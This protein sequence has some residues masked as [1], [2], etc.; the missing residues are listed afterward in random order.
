MK[1]LNSFINSRS[2][3]EI[4]LFKVLW[5]CGC[6]FVCFE[7]FVHPSFLKF[8]AYRDFKNLQSPYNNEE[9]E[10]FLTHFNVTSLPFIKIQ[11]IIKEKAK[12]IIETKQEDQKSYCTLSFQ[13]VIQ[14]DKFFSLLQALSSPTLLIQSFSL[15]S[16]GD[17]SLVLK[18]QKIST[19]SPITPLVS[20]KDLFAKFSTPNLNAL[21]F[22]TPPQPKITFT[23]EA[24]FNQ[25]VK[26]NGTWIGIEESIQGHI[27]KEI[28]PHFIILKN[29]T[30][31]LKLH[32]KEKRIFQ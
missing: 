20:P 17:F 8:Q 7:Y 27:L 25:K 1:P 32:L 12:T 22:Y 9:I 13:G 2:K 3:R 23:L 21:K 10:D 28:Y 24:I 15:D 26:I 18:N 16:K 4:L 30:Q 19:L 11:K 29:D 6:F 5:V 14:T 31:T